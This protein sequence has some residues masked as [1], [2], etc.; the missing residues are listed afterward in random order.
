MPDLKNISSLELPQKFGVSTN[1]IPQFTKII[2]A[3]YLGFL[4]GVPHYMIYN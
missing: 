2:M 1:V 3:S 4:L